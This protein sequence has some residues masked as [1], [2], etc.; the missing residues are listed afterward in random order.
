MVR[1]AAEDRIKRAEA[2]RTR[3]AGELIEVQVGD[4]V[5]IYRPVL[6][7]DVCRWNGVA[8]GT[9]L[10]SL[11]DCLIGVWWQGRNLQ[12]RAQDCR[13]ALAF[14]FAPLVFGKCSS[15]IE[16]FRRA[17]EPFTGC[18]RVGWFKH[19]SS[20]IACEG[21][22]NFDEILAAGIRWSFQCQVRK[23]HQEPAS[24]PF[25]RSIVVLVATATF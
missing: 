1:A 4:L 23:S 16:M 22:R 10:T 12:D 21:N 13:R 3:P 15:P 24:S 19:P 17:A 8:S 5:E 14:V 18:M 2:T 9:D 25:R 7:R 20:W 6:N 11:V